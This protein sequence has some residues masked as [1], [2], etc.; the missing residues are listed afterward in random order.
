MSVSRVLYP[1]KQFLSGPNGRGH[2]L[3]FL[4]KV[5]FQFLRGFRKLHFIGPCVTV[6]GSARFKE[7]NPYYQQG[8][9][10][11][12]MLANMGF[13]VMTGGG[14]G[15]MEAANRGAMEAG[16]LSVGCTIELPHEQESNIYM[17][18]VVD[19]K[20]F[21]VRKVLMTKYSY[22]FV[23]MPGGFGTMDELFEIVTL[24]QTGIVSGFPVV[25][26]G[27]DFY[28][29]IKGLIHKM[30]EEKTISPKDE[31]LI[32]FTDNIEE[33]GEYIRKYIKKNYLVKYKPSW[34]LGEKEVKRTKKAS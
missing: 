24:V 33:A 15:I 8:V 16:G 1:D 30:I 26:I 11:G 23:V 21:F 31:E 12:E 28:K 22:A 3:L 29:D 2:E 32:L 5:F 17:S 10:V 27:T 13:A 20:H 14:P 18:K 4:I 19:F 9:K 34:F 7:D 25:I 6:F